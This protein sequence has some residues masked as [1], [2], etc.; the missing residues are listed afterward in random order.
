MA[1]SGCRLNG[2][3][4]ATSRYG[5][6][7][8]VRHGPPFHSPFRKHSDDLWR[9]ATEDLVMQ[10]E[11]RAVSRQA[12]ERG[13]SYCFQAR[14][15]KVEAPGRAASRHPSG[16]GGLIAQRDREMIAQRKREALAVIHKRLSGQGRA[17]GGGF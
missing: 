5:A 16:D 17:L 13:K 14:H 8:I 4:K 7:Q 3:E 12:P 1:V 11:G 9:N 6:R 10:P 15:L 2:P